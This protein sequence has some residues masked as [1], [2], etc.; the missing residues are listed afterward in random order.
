MMRM[1]EDSQSSLYSRYDSTHREKSSFLHREAQ[2]LN[3]V[4]NTV[5]TALEESKVEAGQILDA[6]VETLN[7]DEE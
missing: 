3:W 1:S 4:K 6:V 5:K 7:G 2:V